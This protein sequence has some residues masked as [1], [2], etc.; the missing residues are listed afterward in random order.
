MGVDVVGY[1]RRLG[2]THTGPASVERLFALHRAHV[3]VVPYET[4]EIHLGR[5]TTIDPL[6]SAE[7]IIA[8][9]GGYCFHLNGAFALLL[10]ELGYDVTRHVGGVYSG[11][12]PAGGATGNHVALTVAVGGD[13]WFVDTGLGDALYEPMP[14][15]PGTV[16]QGPYAYR[17]EPSPVVPGGW[18]FIHDE[19][20]E[21]FAGMDFAPEGVAIESFADTHIELSTSPKSSF[22]AFPQVGRRTADGTDFI[23]GCTLFRTGRPRHVLRSAEEWFGVVADVFGMPLP[24]VGEA[25]R[26]DLYAGFWDSHV[27]HALATSPD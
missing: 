8:G 5:T 9:R 13:R 21:S 14:L 25:Q 22:V 26:S 4:L 2:V 10:E 12:R 11:S 18:R 1:L 23:R 20:A 3:S 27:R 19:T 17:L 7:R 16:S 6:A 24:D 15:E